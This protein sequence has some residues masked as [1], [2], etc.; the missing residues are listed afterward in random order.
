MVLK[1]KRKYKVSIP[2]NFDWETYLILNPDIKEHGY[3]TEE[4]AKYHY[5]TYG[6]F[7]NRTYSWSMDILENYINDEEN[8][9]EKITGN[10]D[11]L[12]SLDK[13]DFLVNK[14]NVK[15]FFRR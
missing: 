1:K 3:D 15:D 8:L 4:N 10:N 12:P 13:N 5:L 14:N 9:F 7:E 2:N 6:F 11:S